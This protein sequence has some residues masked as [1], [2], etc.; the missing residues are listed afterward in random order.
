MPANDKIMEALARIEHK[1]DLALGLAAANA[2][3]DGRLKKVGDPGHV[4]PVCRKSPE[5]QIDIN[6]SVVVRKCDC[7]TGKI[8]L[9]LKAFAPPA[10]PAKKEQDNGEQRSSEEDRSDSTRG[11]RRSGRR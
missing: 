11:P 6:D 9:D 4:C 10:L 5:Y 8:P 1:T 3:V 2:G 7:G